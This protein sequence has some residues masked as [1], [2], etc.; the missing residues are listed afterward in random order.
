M[1]LA[2]LNLIVKGAVIMKT[3]QNAIK[4]VFGITTLFLLIA[5]CFLSGCTGQKT[6]DELVAP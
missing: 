4:K 3:K 5:L 1:K 2:G 6:A